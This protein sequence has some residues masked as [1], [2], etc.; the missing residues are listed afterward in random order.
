MKI[1]T[2]YESFT[3]KKLTIDENNKRR[4]KVKRQLNG[5]FNQEGIE[6]RR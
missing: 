4:M 3:Y 6:D 2:I 5:Y 1:V